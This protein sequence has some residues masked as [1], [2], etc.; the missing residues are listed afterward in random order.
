MAGRGLN[1][2]N[3]RQGIDPCPPDIAFDDGW[4]RAVARGDFE[5]VEHI[6]VFGHND[7]VG[8]ANEMIWHQGG[9]Y[10][11][12]DVATVLDLASSSVNDT[13]AGSGA[14]ALR[15]WG[16]DGNHNPIWEDK[17]LNGQT[18]VPT[19]QKF[20]RVHRKRV[21]RA[22]ATGWNEGAIRTGTGGVAA[23]VPQTLILSNIGI[24]FNETLLAMRT[25]PKGYRG[26][27]D[28]WSAT[29][30]VSKQVQVQLRV[31][32][33]GQVFTVREFISMTAGQ[34]S[35]EQSIGEFIPELADIEIQANAVGGGG[36]IGAGIHITLERL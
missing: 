8:A 6:H 5:D 29:S 14:Q 4:K 7:A 11:Y 2:K 19:T 32:D 28:R 20:L 17:E 33:F 3:I 22:G 25:I 1:W 24:N 9:V 18:S 23:G 35:A 13:A 26:Y 15:I 27:L 16:L 10:T 36:D 34:V 30:S 31:R 12:T 21:I